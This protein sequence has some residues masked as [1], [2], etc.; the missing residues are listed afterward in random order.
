MNPTHVGRLPSG[1][2][3]HLTD[4]NGWSACS[5]LTHDVSPIE[6]TR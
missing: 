6:K 2:R 4:A 3:V 5:R 1:K